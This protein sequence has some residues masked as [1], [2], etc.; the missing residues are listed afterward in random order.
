MRVSL[1]A[2][3]GSL[4]LATSSWAT[5][6]A[7]TFTGTGSGTL[8][9][10]AFG[11]TSFTI[12]ETGDT[13]TVQASPNGHGFFI[14]DAS[15]TIAITG[16]GTFDFVT[17]TLTFVNNAL[18]EVGF[19]RAGPGV[20]LYD[21]PF[22]ASPDLFTWDMRSSIGPINGTFGLLQWDFSPVD[23]NSGVL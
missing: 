11:T 22:S 7:F 2:F 3:I 6:I 15:A 19:S 8:G 23:T 1:I 17:A 13:T 5:P 14:D 10:N 4:T 16:V 12:T 18:G 9:G 21:G 20:D